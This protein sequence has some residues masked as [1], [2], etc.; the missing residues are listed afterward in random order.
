MDIN[1]TK[2]LNNNL[3]KTV[4]NRV[5]LPYQNK[6]NSLYLKPNYIMSQY[7]HIDEHKS[8]SNYGNKFEIQNNRRSNNKGIYVNMKKKNS[9]IVNGKL[10]NN[11]DINI[12]FQGTIIDVT[13]KN[14]MNNKI[15]MK[16]NLNKI[17]NSYNNQNKN[18]SILNNTN[19]IPNERVQSLVIPIKGSSIEANY[20]PKETVKT[21]VNPIEQSIK[22]TN[23]IQKE[24]V[25]SVEQPIK[26]PPNNIDIISSE[27]IIKEEKPIKESNNNPFIP[28]ETLKSIYGIKE[29]L[30]NLYENINLQ[31]T[32]KSVYPNVSNNQNI[33]N[34]NLSNLSK[35]GPVQ[36]NTSENKTNEVKQSKPKTEG[37]Q[38]LSLIMPNKTIVSI[39]QKSNMESNDI[40]SPL[41]NLQ[42]GESVKS[43]Y[44]VDE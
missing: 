5:I 24:T 29:S 43:V 8:K 17:T 16:G 19:I 20:I 38:L 25:K 32:F 9:I 35:V 21:L 40:N 12:D 33:Q 26:E 6:N 2:A 23:I 13:S 11:I 15:N 10:I 34:I 14:K 22:N 3:A 28:K 42:I 37:K 1:S 4:N 44:K 27:K 41:L 7:K 30:N 36:T 18:L 31:E 39:Y